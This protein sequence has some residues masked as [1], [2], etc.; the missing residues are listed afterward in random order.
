MAT[1]TVASMMHEPGDPRCPVA[2]TSTGVDI[3]RDGTTVGYRRLGQGPGLVILH[4]TASSGYNHLRLG[5]A[6]ADAFTVCLPDRRGRGLSGPYRA[7]DTLQTEVEDL[8]AILKA[9]GAQ[10]VFGVSSGGIVSL[11]A[12]LRL[13]GIRHVAVHEPPLFADPTVPQAVLRRFDHA[14]APARLRG[15]SAVSITR[16]EGDTPWPG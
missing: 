9:T 13:P 10:D 3:S 7:D 1:R 2:G 5:A 14:L 4:G 6:L 15:M 12:A 16:P 8:E 11:E